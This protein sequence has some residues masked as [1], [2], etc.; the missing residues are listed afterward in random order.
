MSSEPRENGAASS[1]P[2]ETAPRATPVTK[3]AWARRTAL[4]PLPGDDGAP[5]RG[6]VPLAHRLWP[7]VAGP[8]YSTPDCPIGPDDCWDWISRARAGTYRMRGGLRRAV[9][10]AGRLD[11]GRIRR[12]GRGDG[13]VGAHVA[14]YEVT[15][16]PLPAGLLVRH[17]CDR[18]LCCNPRHLTAGTVAEN[19]ADRARR[20]AGVA[21]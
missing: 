6:P 9:Q 1:E 7:K 11:Y 10:A 15:Y 4:R 17:M 13:L 20:R 3:D 19:G 5:G 21:A 16:G 8:W 12:G 18:G 14:A 2:R